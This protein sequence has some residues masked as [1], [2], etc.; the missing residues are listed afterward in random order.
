L[1]GALVMVQ[2]SASKPHGSFEL[3]YTEAH[4][5][6]HIFTNS[7]QITKGSTSS[8]EKSPVTF[9]A[10]S[11][12]ELYVE[13]KGHGVCALYYNGNKHCKHP[14]EPTPPKFPG[15]DGIVYRYKANAQKPKPGNDQDV[16][17]ALISLEDTLWK[18]RFSICNSNCTFDQNMDYDGVTLGKAFNG[19]TYGDDKANPPWA[20]DDPDETAPS[21]G[22]TSSF[23]PQRACSPMS[24]YRALFPKNMC[25]IPTSLA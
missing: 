13:S 19:N 20:W 5:T 1:E 14:V 18:K 17:Y 9:E 12:P 6:L 11:H 2:K 15:G 10:Q 25:I 16:G 22:E 8:L 4:N 21:I 7:A 23:D 3:M 24:K